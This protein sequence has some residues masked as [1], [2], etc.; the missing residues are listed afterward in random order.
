MS[1]VIIMNTI[2]KLF[3]CC[4]KVIK[5]WTFSQK[6]FISEQRIQ[7]IVRTQTKL[8]IIITNNKWGIVHKLLDYSAQQP[9]VSQGRVC[10]SSAVKQRL[11]KT[12]TTAPSKKKNKVKKKFLPDCFGSDKKFLNVE[13]RE[14]YAAMT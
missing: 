12:T 1:A 11:C 8:F 10:L 13:W 14:K 4:W 9:E 5:N 2:I 3:I 7:E 6:V